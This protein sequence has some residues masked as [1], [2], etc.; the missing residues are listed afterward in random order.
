MALL[1]RE[2]RKSVVNPPIETSSMKEPAVALVERASFVIL[3]DS[4]GV[5]F[6]GDWLILNR[7]IN[8]C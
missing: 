5:S 2:V 6:L 7:I 8:I 3:P 1:T 4:Q